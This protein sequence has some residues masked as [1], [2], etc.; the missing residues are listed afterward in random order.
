MNAEPIIR[1]EPERH[2]TYTLLI[3]SAEKS[4][5]IFEVVIYGLLLVGPIVAVA[6]F[7]RQPINLPAA[8]CKRAVCLACDNQGRVRNP[9]APE[10]AQHRAV[11][12]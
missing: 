6:Q 4:R 3:R 5:N 10:L 2:S 1:D 7:A 8:G 12:G 9:E 11:K